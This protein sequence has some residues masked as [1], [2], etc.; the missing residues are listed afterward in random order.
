[1]TTASENFAPGSLTAIL[2]Q[3]YRWWLPLALLSIPSANVVLMGWPAG[4]RP[5]LEFPYRYEGDLLVHLWMAQ[6][7][8]EGWLFEN[9]RSG[10]PFGSSFLD[11]PGSDA[12]NHLIIKL[13]GHAGGSAHAS[14]NLFFLMSF[15][16]IVMTA[17]GVSRA[18]GLCRAFSLC[19]AALFAFQ[20]F[21]FQRI[22][23]I[24]FTW[25]FVVPVFFYF[26]FRIHFGAAGS[27]WPRVPLIVSILAIA[28]LASFGVYYALFGAVILIV[29]GL[30]AWARHADVRRMVAALGMVLAIAAGVTANIAPNLM[31]D[32]R[33][34]AN[35]EAV[36][37]HASES[38]R[39]GLKLIQLVLPRQ[40]HRSETLAGIARSY[41]DSR[42]LVNENTR[43]SLGIVGAIGLLVLAV[44]LLLKI[45]GRA[46]DERL[47]LL[48]LLALVLFLVGTIGGLGSIFASIVSPLI[49]AW[50]RVSI[51][52][53]F[54][55]LTAFFLA[56]Q[57]LIRRYAAPSRQTV[58][59]GVAAVVFGTVGILDQTA[60]A[61]PACNERTRVGFRLDRE[62][63]AKI[64]QVLPANAAV[65]QLPYLPFPEVP[66]LH[67]LRAY[68]LTIGFVHSRTLRWSYAGMKG[69]EADRFFKA[70]AQKPV[71]E[72]IDVVRRQGFAGVY[73]D[74][75][76]Y[77][78]GA[79]DLLQRL[80]ALLG[81]PAATRGDGEVVFFTLSN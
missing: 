29:A 74:R 43:A 70:L 51:V 65:Y 67:R 56:L 16:A 37:R 15:P 27:I 12:A 1:M 80:T 62:F 7:V 39:Y 34:G 75:R 64:E 10:F 19:C 23:H 49:R 54:A 40:D 61:C 6:R 69:R 33:V 3:E 38:E 14:L 63:I 58:L 77:E 57:L 32:M 71:E 4:L 81:Q 25:Y 31:H 72:Q 41:A 9:P 79:R 66:P 2:R 35:P 47:C 28:I 18:I 8:I 20:A 30:S 60:A 78:D 24:F 52:I 42:P 73:V 11:Y 5:N 13:L 48:G 22:A 76:G 46:V 68:D 55:S 26:G 50:N 36:H 44:A 59:A 17:Y 45:S 21:H 53:A